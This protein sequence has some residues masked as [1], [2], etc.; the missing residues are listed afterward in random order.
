MSSRS[1]IAVNPTGEGDEESGPKIDPRLA[2]I[3]ND[4]WR[5]GNEAIPKENWDYA[6]DMYGKAVQIAPANLTYR[7]SLRATERKKYKDNGTGASMAGMRLMTTRGKVKKA[8]MSKDWKGLADAAEE[9]L[10]VN[11]WDLQLNAALGDACKELNYDDVAI[12]CYEEV[13]KLD[14]MNV[15][16]NKSLGEI[17]E[18]RG[19]YDRAVQCWER[20]VKAEPLNGHA[21]SQVQRISTSKVIDRG[22]YDSASSTREV[23]GD[24]NLQSK[25]GHGPT[26]SSQADGPGMS[27]EADL[28]RAIRKDPQNKDNYLKLADYYRREGNL[29]EVEAQLEKALILSGGNDASIRELVED[30][31]LEQMRIKLGQT[32]A[33]AGMARDDEELKAATKE[34]AKELLR[35]EIEIFK[36]RV[37]RYPADMKL[38]FELGQRYMRVQ[39]WEEAIPLF[40][41]ARGDVRI[42]G[43]SLIALGKCFAYDGKI[44]LARRQFESALPEVAFEDKPDAFKDL[45]YSLA[46]IAEEMKDLAKAEEHYQKVVEVDYAFRDCVA[47]L[48]K[49]QS[50]ASPSGASSEE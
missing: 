20:V 13:L 28:Q 5:K 42:K 29:K 32:K 36:T 46:R 14:P 12:F 31:Q 8:Q 47:R 33:A 7:Q 17:L 4:C 23:M 39:N 48:D 11:P 9:G 45:H 30:V 15:A 27:Q 41:Q 16:V 10:Q 37:E 24:K 2:K 18:R 3:A 22:G 21:R 6:I 25:M 40:Q 34:L 44:P 43:E 50:G 19:E 38:K 35:R 49:L 1:G 26:P